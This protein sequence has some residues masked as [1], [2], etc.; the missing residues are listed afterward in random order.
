MV[1]DFVKTMDVLLTY[2]GTFP[3]FSIFM[4]ASNK[5]WRLSRIVLYL[6]CTNK[7]ISTTLNKKRVLLFYKKLIPEEIS[8]NGGFN[9]SVDMPLITTLKHYELY[10]TILTSRWF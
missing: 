10:V 3:S 9:I 5:T 2:Q 6:G 7:F 8:Q 4:G 1:R